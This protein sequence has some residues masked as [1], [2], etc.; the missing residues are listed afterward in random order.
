MNIQPIVEGYG[1]V[2]AVPVLLRR[3]CDE[4]RVYQAEV[5]RPIRRNRSELVQES[6][7][8]KSV[9]LA[10]LQPNCGAILIV[11]DGDDD[12]PR[13]LAPTIQMWARQESQA[14][15]CEVVIAYRE[16]EAWFLAAVD[17][18][19]GRHG[20]R[21]DAAFPGDPEGP[22]DAKGRLEGLMRPG[23][24]YSETADQAPLTAEFDM[25]AAY[26]R[27]RSFR[28]MTSAFGGLLSRLGIPAEQWPPPNWT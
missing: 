14:V 6:P 2:A 11:F 21:G 24:S 10:L 1:D 19:R 18:L 7:L 15:P 3:L 16:Y 26:A 4:A 12:C 27:S 23:W 17:S 28:R 8:R 22:R 25:V 5:N 13:E 9:Q 20:L